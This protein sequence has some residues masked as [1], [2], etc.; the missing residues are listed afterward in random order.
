MSQTINFNTCNS[1]GISAWITDDYESALTNPVASLRQ[2]SNI[3]FG[4]VCISLMLNAERHVLASTVTTRP[5]STDG[6]IPFPAT[7]TRQQKQVVLCRKIS[8]YNFFNQHFKAR[9][10]FHNLSLTKPTLVKV[11]PNSMLAVCLPFPL[12]F[13]GLYRIN[14]KKNERTEKNFKTMAIMK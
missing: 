2:T 4:V 3:S 14:A 11:D 9:K 7:N 10:C 5:F 6:N 12:V 13:G 1:T 8:E